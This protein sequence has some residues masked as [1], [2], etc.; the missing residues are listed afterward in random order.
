MS[1]HRIL[2]S[3]TA[4]IRAVSVIAAG[5]A[6]TIG[7][8]TAANAAAPTSTTDTGSVTLSITEPIPVMGTAY[9]T[10]SCAAGRAYQASASSVPIRGFILSFTVVAPIYHGPGT[11]NALLALTLTEPDGTVIPLPAGTVPTAIT[12]TGGTSTIDR[13]TPNGI[14]VDGSLSW[15]CSA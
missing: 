7:L 2:P 15:T 8:T 3:G 9:T 4:V 12:A 10:V 11:Y 6:M 5:L 14:P 1:R 13:Q